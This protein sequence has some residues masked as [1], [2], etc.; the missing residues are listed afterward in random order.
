MNHDSKKGDKPESLKKEKLEKKQHREKALKT[1]LWALKTAFQINAG[2]LI[3]W[4]VLSFL[5]SLAPAFFLW[6]TQNVVNQV[7]DALKSHAGVSNLSF[8]IILLAFFLFF[9]DIYNLIPQ[10]LYAVIHPRYTK[11]M[12]QKFIE[13]ANKLPGYQYERNDFAIMQQKTCFVCT[14]LANFVINLL[15]IPSS[16]IGIIGILVVAART[17]V[18][19]L[20][21]GVIFMGWSIVNGIIQGRN[22]EKLNSIT[23]REY[24]FQNT[25]YDYGFKREITHEVR[26]L[27]AGW[28]LVEK[29]E[30]YTK[31]ILENDL[32]WNRDNTKRNTIRKIGVNIAEIAIFGLG[33]FFYITGRID[34]GGFTVL[35][36]LFNQMISST[37]YIGYSFFR[38]YASL[39]YLIDQRDFFLTDFGDESPR[40]E[41][42]LTPLVD[43]ENV[44]E[45]RHV[46]HRYAPDKPLTLNDVSF[47]VKKG[48]IVSLVGLNGAGKT[49]IIK[50]LLDFAKPESGEILF[51]GR[52]IE[53]VT[54]YEYTQCVGAVFQYSFTYDF[55]LRE[56][57][58]V[59]DIAKLHDDEALMRAARLGGAEKII[60]HAPHGLDN[61]VGKSF[62]PDGL[63]L[64]GGEMQR[65]SLART[66]MI[67]RDIMLLDEPAAA[68]D[69]IAELQQYE[70][71]KSRIIGH[72]A[73]LVSHRIS[74]SRL[75][76]R[77][78]VLDKGRVA[79]QG[80]HE[81]L[82]AKNGLYANMFRSQAQWYNGGGDSVEEKTGHSVD[83]S[84]LG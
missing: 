21:P 60:E 42:R 12:E 54:R 19:L 31:P 83:D 41:K 80:T 49:T 61:Y 24:N 27:N 29:W 26:A 8:T 18:W 55:T 45:M 69:P 56:N 52:P 59:A 43:T 32:A 67:G 51:Y 37:D 75:A 13:Q 82:M 72:T 22:L 17:S 25:F 65:L 14:E 23:D 53:D 68:L 36:S 47:Q 20:I 71:I 46:F 3:C 64:S 9:N 79:E 78:I 48:E 44:F 76:D 35:P 84:V 62:V 57:I 1:S 30:K 33:M 4:T 58:G 73:I 40:L 7:S 34:I 11:A 70:K 28:L 50:L 6:L 16:L 15:S 39:K 77:I 81:E 66:Q 63:D 10:L 38:P 74:F 2:S 5:G